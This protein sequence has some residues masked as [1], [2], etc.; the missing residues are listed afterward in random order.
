MRLINNCATINLIITYCDILKYN[1]LHNI[2]V[3][4]NVDDCGIF[5][6]N[7]NLEGE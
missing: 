7:L 1:L 4:F 3:K 5:N 6:F 2:F